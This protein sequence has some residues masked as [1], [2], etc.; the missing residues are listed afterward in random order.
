MLQVYTKVVSTIGPSTNTPEMIERLFAAGTDVFRLNMSHGDHAGHS[1]VVK[2]IRE[3]SIKHGRPAGILCDISGP[4]IRIGMIPDSPVLLVPDQC[5]TLT[6]D[7]VEGTAE[8]VSVSYPNLPRDVQVGQRLMLDDGLLEWEVEAVEGNNVR[9][10]VIRGGQLSSRKGLNLP[11]TNLSISA[12]TE[13]DRA[14]IEWGLENDVDVF[15]ISFVRTAADLRQARTYMESLGGNLPLI[16]KIEK[17]EAVENIE[18][19][20]READGAMVA[21]GDLGVEIPLERVPH[22]QKRVIR[23]CNKL[24]KPVITATQMLD[25]MIR[26]ARPTRAEVTDVANA[27]L[28]GTDAV[29]LSGETAAGL[30]PIE[31]V[32]IMGR[33]AEE[34]E[35]NFNYQRWLSQRHISESAHVQDAISTSAALIARDIKAAKILCLTQS[36]STVRRVARYHPQ[37]GILA[38]CPLARTAQQLCLSWGVTALAREGAVDVEVE[39]RQG[40]EVQIRKA[41]SL[42]RDRG[43]LQSG[44]TIV[45]VAGLPLHQPSTT[46]LVRV[47]EVD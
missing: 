13:K 45:V 47:V 11:N 34:T 36:G 10:R 40:A 24:G 4:K 14:D 46:N 25:S 3:I 31:A 44:Q 30:Y 42:F 26:S 37:E 17:A 28:D 16:A 7:T 5:I 38:Y 9:C 33:I 22:V 23:M 43:F 18:D 21:R 15:A 41:I 27:I 39:R 12:I 1:A 35:K 20:L 32:E 6:T 19:I 29:M 2:A 8:L